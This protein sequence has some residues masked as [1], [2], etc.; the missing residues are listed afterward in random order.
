[1]GGSSTA[2]TIIVDKRGNGDHT[3][4][5][6]AIDN[7]AENDTVRVWEGSYKEDI[8]VDKPLQL[9]GNGTK[10]T[11]IFG[12]GD[13]D[14]A[15]INSD[16][17]FLDGF[18]FNVTS[19]NYGIVINGANIVLTNLSTPSNGNSGIYILDSENVIIIGCNASGNV[20]SGLLIE[21]TSNISIEKSTFND[22]DEY[23]ASMYIS[24]NVTIHSSRFN[25]NYHYGLFFR[26]TPN[27]QIHDNEISFNR[28]AGMAVSSDSYNSSIINNT[29][30][31]NTGSGII[32][33]GYSHVFK[34]NNCSFN[35]ISGISETWSELM[36]GSVGGI[37]ENNSLNYNGGYGL[38]LKGTDRS[39]IYNNNCT[40]N[41][42][43]G[44]YIFGYNS[45]LTGN[46]ASYNR[47]YG[48]IT[49]YHGH[50]IDHNIVHQNGKSGIKIGWIENVTLFSNDLWLNSF[51]VS[52]SDSIDSS[53]L[54]LD[55]TNTVNGKPVE[56]IHGTSDLE[57]PTGA[58]QIIIANSS[59]VLVKGQN[60]SNGSYG[61]IVFHS[62]NITVENNDLSSN[63]E[64]GIFISSSENITLINNKLHDIR[65]QGVYISHSFHNSIK[66]N[67]LYQT[68][69]EGIY[70]FQSEFVSIL[71]NTF[72][73]YSRTYIHLFQ[74]SNNV[75]KGNSIR[76]GGPIG[77]GLQNSDD[78]ELI[79]NTIY[80][81][82]SNGLYLKGSDNNNIT[83]NKVLTSRSALH[84]DGSSYND[85]FYN[86][87]CNATY[88]YYMD[89]SEGNRILNNTICNNTYG[90]KAD[91]NSEHNK[92]NFNKIYNNENYGFYA[93][94]G[95]NASYN[96]W[97]HPTGPKHYSNS[98]G[99]GDRGSNN[100]D[101]MPWLTTPTEVKLVAVI[102]SSP[103]PSIEYGLSASFEGIGVYPG[104]EITG[105]HWRSSLDGSLNINSSFS[106]TN[107]S[108]GTH[109][110]HF[111]VQDETGNWSEETTEVLVIF[112]KPIAT[113]DSVMPRLVNE[114]DYIEF[115]GHGNDTDGTIIAHEWWLEKDSVQSEVISNKS[116]FST[117]SIPGGRYRVWYR[118]QDNG[119]HWSEP[120]S[121]WYLDVNSQPYILMVVISPNPVYAN[122]D[123]EFHG[124]VRDNETDIKAY[125]WYVD[126]WLLSD[127]WIKNVHNITEWADFSQGDQNFTIRFRAQDYDDYWTPWYVETLHVIGNRL[128]RVHSIEI[129]PITVPGDLYYHFTCNCTDK[130]GNIVEYRWISDK[131]GILSNLSTFQ[132]NQLTL[133]NHEISLQ[134]KDNNFTW[135]KLYNAS[136]R[137]N[138]IPVAKLEPQLS[139]LVHEDG[140]TWLNGTGNDSD[141]SIEGFEWSSSIDGVIGIQSNSLV[142]NLTPGLHT[143]SFR[144]QDNDNVWSE[145][146]QYQLLVNSRPYVMNITIS[147]SLPIA[148]ESMDL[149]GIGKDLDGRITAY[150]WTYV[151]GKIL[152]SE[153]SLNLSDLPA[154]DQIILLQV[155][156]N[157]GAWSAPFSFEFWANRRPVVEIKS[158][159]KPTASNGFN[160]TFSGT[161]S[162]PDGNVSYIA[163]YS[164]QMGLIGY[165]TKL[166][167]KNM[168]LGEHQIYFRVKDE[169]GTWSKPASFEIKVE[170]T[171]KDDTKDLDLGLLAVVVGLLF[172]VAVTAL[173]FV[174]MKSGDKPPPTTSPSKKSPPSQAY[175]KPLEGIHKPIPRQTSEE[176][177]VPTD[178]N[179]ESVAPQEMATI[180]C[181]G[182]QA[183]MKI[184]KLGRLQNVK[185]GAC[186][187]SGQV[188]I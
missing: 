105:Y 176:S 62:N 87:L 108:L 118:V 46:N 97:G 122:G 41:D 34:K 119:G 95:N 48:I 106:L 39:S 84:S 52:F 11:A 177:S 43:S 180:E 23:G 185:C 99:S 142:S 63:K 128:P 12:T 170:S 120:V 131:D 31:Y 150:Q 154:G 100:L 114:G 127:N 107:L 32:S 65:G 168:S 104:R 93:S 73:A 53:L 171:S 126:D 77:I 75:I 59:R 152:A 132:T 155:Q 188:E 16:W 130:D 44:I 113:I 45:T 139:N 30:S 109:Q 172:L 117:N 24:E 94:K 28:L 5:Q 158:I 18:Q 79:N 61:I 9:I 115:L 135:S 29:C 167:R 151:Q 162:D 174:R 169:H 186:G 141:G 111:K 25:S 184:P 8:L 147:T 121:V 49:S 159:E 22:N 21:R 58:G 14:V 19:Y 15:S 166:V 112:F 76:G 47:M 133:G 134:V 89:D 88:G 74:S 90:I 20:K 81:V 137:V 149:V 10:T 181:P 146:K 68:R 96:W 157:H 82:F 98:G 3:S 145:Y 144:V 83:G 17:V 71:N 178:K 1:M 164:D 101:I 60:L 163:W 69:D 102:E 173:V 27:N 153:S 42:Q 91:G 70:L 148:G 116:S 67:D 36:D 33:S 57:V 187:L 6:D 85:V 55:D 182:C 86:Y 56:Y 54:D 160:W 7:A 129:T 165:G 92:V 38:Y 136:L 35:G 2:D 51:Q 26:D 80:W 13:D 125:E 103:A 64:R 140:M 161:A 138:Y 143:V 66:N 175:Q 40:N 37:Y 179:Q 183:R 4:I 72:D 110:I 78:N 123:M 124:L 156:D 50:Q